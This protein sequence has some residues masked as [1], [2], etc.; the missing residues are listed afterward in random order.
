MLIGD[1]RERPYVDTLCRSGA[2]L[3]GSCQGP[4]LLML[5][6]QCEPPPRPRQARFRLAV[7]GDDDFEL[8][9]QAHRLVDV[10]VERD[11]R[12]KPDPRPLRGRD[13]LASELAQHATLA[14]V[15]GSQHTAQVTGPAPVVGCLLRRAFHGQV[16]S[17]RG[18][19]EK[20]R[21][22]LQRAWVA[23]HG[24]QR[25]LLKHASDRAL[26][27]EDLTTEVSV[28]GLGGDGR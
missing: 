4:A 26:C 18:S 16:E 12:R 15:V 7:I 24:E 6:A 25:R 1:A 23:E 10:L 3:R 11:D 19:P 20:I 5:P 22:G 27:H 14:L 8:R 9:H 13:V 21:A 28:L 17:R 2:R